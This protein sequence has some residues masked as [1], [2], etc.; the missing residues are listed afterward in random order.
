M[1]TWSATRSNRDLNYNLRIL[2]GNV[3]GSYRFLGYDTSHAAGSE[4]YSGFIESNRAPGV[5]RKTGVWGKC[6]SPIA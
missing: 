6:Y 4:I 5:G 2:I 3:N 1:E